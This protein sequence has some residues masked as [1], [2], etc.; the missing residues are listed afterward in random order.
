MR[1]KNNEAA[2]H[3]REKP[4]LHEMVLESK[5]RSL[6]EENTTIKAELL[7]LKLRNWIASFLAQPHE[8]QNISVSRSS[9]CKEFSPCTS[10]GTHVWI[11]VMKPSLQTHSPQ[12]FHMF[13]T[14]ALSQ[15]GPC[16]SLE[17]V[18]HELWDSM[19]L[20]GKKCDSYDFHARY[21]ANSCPEISF[22]FLTVLQSRCI[23][24]L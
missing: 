5:L 20:T 9:C 6:V 8:M 12:L 4:Y 14:A 17:D 16:R 13:N 22:R 3:L 18:K 7:S 23:L 2:R 19:S 10:L 11:S 24:V 15:K 1:R 21:V